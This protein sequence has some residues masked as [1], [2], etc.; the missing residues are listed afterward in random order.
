MLYRGNFNG[1]RS[2]PTPSNLASDFEYSFIMS[3]VIKSLKAPHIPPPKCCRAE[4]KK[5]F[6]LLL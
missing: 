2:V 5:T 4:K 1:N 3:D 6:Y